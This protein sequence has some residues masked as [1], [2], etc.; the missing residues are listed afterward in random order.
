MKNAMHQSSYLEWGKHSSE[1]KILLHSYKLQLY[2]YSYLF[3]YLTSIYRVPTLC[4]GIV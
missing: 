4:T 1:W 3:I 2:L